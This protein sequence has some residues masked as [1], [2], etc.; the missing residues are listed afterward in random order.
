MRTLQRSHHDPDRSTDACADG[1]GGE[2]DTGWEGGA[3][4]RSCE[5]R[6]GEGC[7]EE[8]SHDGE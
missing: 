7:D 6:F 1:E 8:E 4:C 2:E 5:E 3:E